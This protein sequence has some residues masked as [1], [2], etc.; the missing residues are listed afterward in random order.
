MTG[1][2]LAGSLDRFLKILLRLSWLNILFILFTLLGAGILGFFPAVTAT[3]RVGRK[4]IS[5]KS[6]F[7]LYQVFK[8]TYKKEF[9]KA[10]LVGFI[11]VL[12]GGVLFANYYAI[13]WLE[14]RVP[15]FVVFAYYCVI[16]LYTILAVWAF[17]LLSYYDAKILQNLKNALIIGITKLPTT[18]LMVVL[19]FIILYVSLQIPSLLLFFSF[20]LIALSNAY[21]S[22]RVFSEID[23][24]QGKQ[25]RGEEVLFVNNKG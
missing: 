17:P 8:D 18:I 5:E 16:I 11:L 6:E 22:S 14:D 20:S 2:Q 15:V 3:I 4:W 21:L 9:I 25:I 19:L 7:P 13:L 24:M 12:V 23:N 10:N 1:E